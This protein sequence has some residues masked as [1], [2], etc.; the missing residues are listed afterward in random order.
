MFFI[1]K[2]HFVRWPNS[3]ELFRSTEIENQTFD[4]VGFEFFF[5]FVSSISFDGRTPSNSIKQKSSI[6]YE[7]QTFDVIRRDYSVVRWQGWAKTNDTDF[8]GKLMVL[9]DMQEIVTHRCTQ[10]F[11]V[12]TRKII[13]GSWLSN[14]LKVIVLTRFF[15]QT[16]TGNGD[17]TTVKK[18]ILY[19]GVLTRWLRFVV[20]TTHDRFS[21]MRTEVF[22]VKYKPGKCGSFTFTNINGFVL[23]ILL[24]PEWL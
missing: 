12:L 22:G 13:V 5:F 16:F 7:N 24:M 9:S 1:C 10:N 8:S 11:I 3:I 14:R 6:V 15:F 2:F 20:K 21:C 4:F 19:E 23:L 17:Q 18:N